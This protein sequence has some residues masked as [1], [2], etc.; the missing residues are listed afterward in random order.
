MSSLCQVKAIPG[1]DNAIICELMW[2]DPSADLREYERSTRGTG[3]CFGAAAIRDF[4]KIMK[5]RHIIRAHQ[6]VQSSVGRFAGD[7]VVTVFSSMLEDPSGFC[8]GIYRKRVSTKTSVRIGGTFHA[9]HWFPRTRGEA[10][11]S[12]Q[13]SNYRK[14]HKHSD[15]IKCYQI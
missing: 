1:Y 14:P 15:E 7:I 2:S 10:A 12:V 11:G 9:I 8:G 6:F 3:A 5:I 4:Q 13:Y